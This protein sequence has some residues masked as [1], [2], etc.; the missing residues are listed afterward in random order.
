MFAFMNTPDG[1]HLFYYGIIP[2]E[3]ID[4]WETTSIIQQLKF[5][6]RSIA[7]DG[8]A[9]LNEAIYSIGQRHPGLS[10]KLYGCS[11]WR[12]VIHHS[13]LFEVDKR[14]SPTGVITWYRTRRT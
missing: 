11:S 1:K 7:K 6:E 3:P 5:A 2:G 8:W 4:N 9:Q 10:P 12:E 14:L 13:Q